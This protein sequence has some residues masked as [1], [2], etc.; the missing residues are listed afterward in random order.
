M[1]LQGL[2]LSHGLKYKPMSLFKFMVAMCINDLWFIHFIYMFN[3]LYNIQNRH[4][5]QNPDRGNFQKISIPNN[6]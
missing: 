5:H 1:E 4:H 6:L 2:A 3:I